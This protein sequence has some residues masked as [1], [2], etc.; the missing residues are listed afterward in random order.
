MTVRE[1]ISWAA[2]SIMLIANLVTFIVVW[3]RK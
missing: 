3:N 1:I 2:I